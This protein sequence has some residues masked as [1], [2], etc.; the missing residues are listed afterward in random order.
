MP[1]LVAKY[2]MSTVSTA[3]LAAHLR[4]NE[5]SEEAL[6]QGFLDAA[7]TYFTALTARTLDEDEDDGF[8]EGVPQ[9][10]KLAITLL[11]AHYY[12]EREAYSTDN[13][14]AVPGGFLALC[15]LYSRQYISPGAM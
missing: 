10:V 15:R 5:D 2:S 8:P 6:L 3:D 12:A 13:L 14:R 9:A 11:A 4:I 1:G 7:E